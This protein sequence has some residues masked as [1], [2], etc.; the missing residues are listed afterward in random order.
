MKALDGTI[1][2]QILEAVLASHLKHHVSTLC[3][4]QD[5]DVPSV[6]TQGL[7]YRYFPCQCFTLYLLQN[8]TYL[9][10][11]S[12]NVLCNM[13]C[14]R[15]L[16]ACLITGIYDISRVINPPLYYNEAQSRCS[17]SNLI[18]YTSQC[19]HVGAIPPRKH[20]TVAFTP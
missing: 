14:N 5:S 18:R 13:L 10:M 6:S 2:I 15:V 9:Y 4:Q 1:T 12:C 8:S 11:L 7:L 20:T 19:S 3:Y 16:I 17:F